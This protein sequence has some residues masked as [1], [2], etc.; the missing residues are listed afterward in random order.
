MKKRTKSHI[1]R[2]SILVLMAMAVCYIALPTWEVITNFELDEILVTNATITSGDIIKTGYTQ[3]IEETSIIEIIEEESMS[4]TLIG[5]PIF[6]PR[7]VIGKTIVGKLVDVEFK[8]T[9]LWIFKKN[10][11]VL[12]FENSK[13]GKKTTVVTANCA[14]QQIWHKGEIQEITMINGEIKT[15]QIKNYEI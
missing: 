11:V 13:D 4:M 8:E 10:I 6:N 7:K 1:F 12:T 15:V 14:K 3:G 9:G 2:V 5:L